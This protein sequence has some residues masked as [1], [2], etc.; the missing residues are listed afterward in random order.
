MANFSDILRNLG[1]TAIK[2]IGKAEQALGYLDPVNAVS[3]A[4]TS[5]G[6]LGGSKA[7]GSKAPGEII[8]GFSQL[9]DVF[10]TPNILQSTVLP[11]GYLTPKNPAEELFQEFGSEAPIAALTGG[12]PGVLSSLVGNIAGQGAKH[13]GNVGPLGQ[14]AIQFG[15]ELG[16]QKF[17]NKIPLPKTLKGI[18]QSLYSQG[19]AAIPAEARAKTNKIDEAYN[20]LAKV[21][22]LESDPSIRKVYSSTLDSVAAVDKH[23]LNPVDIHEARVNLNKLIRKTPERATKV[24]LGKTRD[25][26]NE[27]MVDSAI[28][29]AKGVGDI[30]AGDKLSAMRHYPNLL[31]RGID[32]LSEKIFPSESPKLW[33][34]LGKFIDLGSLALDT[35]YHPAKSIVI[36]GK[37][38]QAYDHYSKFVKAVTKGRIASATKFAKVL[39][40]DLKDAEDIDDTID[41]DSIFA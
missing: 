3:G 2:G 28:D 27:A 17:G 24:K 34:E 26:L 14:A 5:L 40:K 10:S 6:L 32:K 21:R 9:G 18:E 25:K 1:S 35:L 37:N 31:S 13:L 38:P 7:T 22:N 4:L 41:I 12:L 39:E 30:Q 11:S 33:K 23:G 8:R 20:E 19:K 16:A 36:A 29:Y 15:A